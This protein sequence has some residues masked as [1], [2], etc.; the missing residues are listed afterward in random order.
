MQ[1]QAFRKKYRALRKELSGATVETLS[2]QIANQ[3]LQLPIW[4][5]TYYHLFLPIV[6]NKEVDTEP[7]L[8]IL[9]GRDKSVVLPKTNFEHLEMKSI[10][11]QE[12]TA[13]EATAF[14]I[15]EPKSGIAIPPEMID[16]V[17]VPLLAFDL[18]GHRL[19]YGK[20]FYDRFL[21]ACKDTVIVVGLSFFEAEQELPKKAHDIPMNYCVTPIK[22]YQFL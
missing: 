19:G 7:I 12:N 20:G 10:L 9:Q 17:F 18:Q 15:P 1:K 3:C 16:V 21:E 4:E 2:L 6:K 8:H 13:I 5:H 14:G 11:L 22:N